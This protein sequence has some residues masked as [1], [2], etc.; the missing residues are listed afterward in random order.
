VTR[1]LQPGY[2]RFIDHFVVEEQALN[3][4][5]SF[6]PSIG[7]VIEYLKRSRN[8]QSYV[9]GKDA[10]PALSGLL[11]FFKRYYRYQLA[12]WAVRWWTDK[13]QNKEQS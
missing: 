7:S 2:L 13:N 10:H 11:T 6:V 8:Y 12:V 3:G 4:S 5:E 1:K 9:P